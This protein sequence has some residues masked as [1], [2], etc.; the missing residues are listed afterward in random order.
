MMM[1]NNQDGLP[2]ISIVTPSYNQG[3]YIEWTVRSVLCQ[4]YP[5]LEYIVM[6]GGSTDETLARIEPYKAQLAHF[7]SGPDGGQSAAIAKGFSL[8]SG[9]IMA[10]LNSDDVLLPGTLNYVADYFARHPHVDVIYSHRYFIDERN[11]VTGLWILPQHSSF[12]MRRLDLIPQETCF[13]RR[14]LF[15]K[16]GNVDPTFQFAMD[17]DLFMRFMNQGKFRRVN[18]FLGAF[19]KHPLSKF[20]TQMTTIGYEE[21]NRLHHQH[22]IK[23]VWVVSNLFW[24]YVWLVSFLHLKSRKTYPG[25]PPGKDFNLNEVWDGLLDNEA[26]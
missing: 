9:E 15:E 2:V 10:Y 4:Q 24:Y 18:R 7:E 22:K 12:L 11:Q 23:S 13:W 8:S 21:I 20:S 5:K 17:Y 6:D 16:A 19:R 1:I 26:L 25:L 14:S 3:Q